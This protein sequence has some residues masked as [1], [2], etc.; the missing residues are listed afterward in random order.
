MWQGA[1]HNTAYSLAQSM[2]TTNKI[3]KG[4][5]GGKRFKKNVK[6]LKKKGAIPAARARPETHC[7]TLEV[8]SAQNLGSSTSR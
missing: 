2:T 3:V 7:A 5:K 1:T 6:A 4:L 8:V